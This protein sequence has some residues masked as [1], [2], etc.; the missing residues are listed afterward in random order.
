MSFSIY[1]S[2]F[3]L[4]SNLFDWE[5][6]LN[7]FSDWAE[8]VSIGTT[9]FSNDNT[10]KLLR[11][12]VDS[13]D[14]VKLVVTDFSLES[15]TFDG[16]IKNAALHE[17]TEYGKILLDLD[18]YIPISQKP[19]WV[20]YL[21][22][23]KGSNIDGYLIPSVNLCGSMDTYKDIGYKFYLH[24]PGLNR[25]VWKYARNRDGSIDITKSD[26]TEAIDNF[27]NLGKFDMLPNNI[28][29]LRTNEIPYVFHKWAVDLDKRIEQN[30]FWK[31]VW[32]NR[33]KREVDDIILDKR[34]IE[35][36]ETFEHLLPLE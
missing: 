23:L 2:A 22:L 20:K 35:N 13:K 34:S 9:C 11:D 12:Y 33:A 16:D 36:I 28:E 24:K 6:T 4:E 8:E 5:N 25:G 3:N 18:E 32:Q 10:V 1:V 31:P 21:N 7:Q 19:L 30:K 26:S 15:P 29:T 17:T 27:G 14:N